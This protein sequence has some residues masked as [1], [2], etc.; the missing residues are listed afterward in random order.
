MIAVSVLKRGVVVAVACVALVLLSGG[1]SAYAAT[2][3]WGLS[4]GARPSVLQGGV[5][6]DEV[7]ELQVNATEGEF[8]VVEP[9]RLKEV[10][11]GK[12]GFGELLKAVIPYNAEASVVQADLEAGVYGAGNVEVTGSGPGDRS[13][14][15]VSFKG[16]RGGQPLAL[17]DTELE[18]LGP[19]LNGEAKVSEVTQGLSDGQLIVT[20]ENLGDADT[21]GATPVVITDKIPAGLTA[22]AAE[23]IAGTPVGWGGNRGQVQCSVS[24]RSVSCSFAGALRPY[25][26]I[27]LRISVVVAKGASF[28]GNNEVGVFGGGAIRGATLNGPVPFGGA[29]PFGVQEYATRFEEAGGAPATQAG[30]HPYQVSATLTLNQTAGGE[31][32]G[33]ARDLHIQLPQGLMANIASFPQCDGVQSATLEGVHNSC[34]AKT[35]IG[36]AMVTLNPRLEGAGLEGLTTRAFP[37]FNLT[38]NP[39]EPARFGFEAEQGA[40]ITLDTALRTG[41]DYGVTLNVNN[42]T[43]V[44][45]FLGS[46]VAIWGVPGDPSHDSS[47]GWGCLSL[48][49]SE[50]G[51]CTP[52]G[53]ASPLPL[54]TLP[55]S[56]VGPLH[57]TVQLDS[58]QQPG[59]FTPQ[60]ESSMGIEGMDG[61]GRL[62]FTPSVDVT[63]DAQAG[64]A[65]TGFG[66]DVH[67]PNPE[68]AQG[69]AEANLQK[70]VV[71]LPAGVVVNPGAA[72]GLGACS[73]EQIGLSDAHPA[74]CPDAAKVGTAE[75]VSPSLHAPLTGS[76]YVA[77][78]G[79]NPFGSLLAL[80]LV[81]EGEG[82][83]VKVAGEVHLDPVTGQVTTTFDNVPQQP[84]SDI[85]L[86][87]FGGSRAALT[88]PPGCGTYTTTSQ[89]TPY[90]SSTAVES[91][92]PFQITSGANGTGCGGQ[93]FAPSF[94]AGT[95][96]NQ[97]GG[98][99]PL[100][101]TFSR[102]DQEQD[103]GAIKLTTPPG[104]LGVLK[105]VPLCGEP[106][107]AQG[108]CGQESLIGRTTVEAGAGS[109]PVTVG[110][111][112]F[113]TG[114][115][116]GAPFGLSIV[117]PAV[118]GPFNLGTVVVR[119]AI[120]VDPVTTALTVASDPLPRIL[121]GIPLQIR[122]V[123]VTIDRP[124]FIFNPTDCEPLT[125]NGTITSG[126]GAQAQVSSRFQAANCAPLVFHPTLTASS[127]AKT[128]LTNGAA[129]DVKVSY[130]SGSQANIHS[131]A[132]ALPTQLP[133]R[134]STIQQAC[135][136]AIFESNPASCDTGS[137]IG[138]GTAYTPIFNN[139]EIGPAYLVSH[140]GAAFP[141]VDVVLQGEGVTILLVGHINISRG[142]VTSA[143]FFAV[144]DAP[145]SSFD[146]SLPEGPHSG[147]SAVGSLCTQALSMPTTITG[148]NGAVIRQTT[149]IKVTG[150]PAAKK[151]TKKHKSKKHKGKKAREGS[152]GKGR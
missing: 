117:V 65:P 16:A 7:Q 113:L 32:A 80:Y 61:C 70:A 67:I 27:E 128:S 124:G 35:A 93:S 60:L 72:N 143:T 146:L 135:P 94:S 4:S 17:M 120:G 68:N 20:A 140:G 23:G 96:N 58:W 133:A 103:L 122:T 137:M 118:V 127:L 119:A 142:G 48:G 84:I 8:V 110:G 78:Q 14:Y 2:P 151:K 43:Q 79:N 121:Q 75:A 12:R 44:S 21:N 76:V 125:L 6:K 130:P 81:L 1:V 42:I 98:F 46:T 53:Q 85:K 49:P 106:Q 136:A 73:P 131:V 87:L 33:L 148:Q 95:T 97:A 115:Y 13:P 126:Q 101:V 52:L 15:L 77:Q 40:L 64:G 111:Q 141:D 31:E 29:T 59:V 116:K 19:G 138:I 109:D 34:P 114:P 57:S 89:L 36:V 107:A 86:H 149:K 45:A 91:S 66:V 22:V 55:T 129:L 3:W 90:S 139:P 104:L 132:V 69:L 152:A 11:E 147:L 26:Q 105:T 25:E 28:I 144:P 102:Q 10:F 112:V 38:P 123:N 150:C 18:F 9:A 47:R 83:L 37:V 50:L 108:T 99:S 62:Q 5:A 145:I 54:L 24:S 39:G 63:P 41:G 74:S 88:T 30:S 71:K 134:L 56:C 51:S 82:V 92:S 100:S